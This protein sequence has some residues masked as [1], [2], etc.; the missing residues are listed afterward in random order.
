LFAAYELMR[1]LV[2]KGKR[3]KDTKRKK[4]KRKKRKRRE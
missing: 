3:K 2:K 4:T 1:L